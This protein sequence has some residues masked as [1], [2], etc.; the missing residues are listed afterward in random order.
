MALSRLV[1]ACSLILLY[2]SQPL[3]AEPAGL[4]LTALDRYVA[5]PDSNY[6]YELSQTITGDDYVTFIVNMTSQKYLTKK[7]VNLPVWEHV[8][9]ITVPKKV[10]SKVGYLFVTGGEKGDPLRDAAPTWNIDMAR[11][12]GTVVTTLYMVPNQPLVFTNDANTSRIEDSIVA[13]TWDKYLRSGDEKWPLRLP[14]TKAVVRAMDTV[15]NLTA[16]E[17]GGG[18]EVQKF[19]VAGASKRGWATWTTAAVDKR[20]IAIVPIVIDVLNLEPSFKHH[21]EV[22]GK[23]AAAVD[24]YSE[25]GIMQ[26]IDTPEYRAL[27]KLVEPY[28]YRDR[29]MLP[30]YIVSATGDQFFLPDS[31]QF[32]WSGLIGEKH[33]RYV[34]NADHSLADTDALN[35]V[36]AWYHAIVNNVPVPRYS[37]DVAKDGTIS[38][39][40][41]DNPLSVTLWVAHNPNARNF[42][43]NVIGNAYKPTPLKEVEPGRYTVKPEVPHKGH[44][45]YFVEMTYASGLEVPFKFS[46]GVKILPDTLKYSWQKR[47]V[48]S[49]APSPPKV[50]V[51]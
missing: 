44:I 14:M 31:W 12:T 30:K 49:S 22:Y 40:T 6:R 29:L 34:A 18:I 15:S 38:V 46:T 9:T 28:E 17:T 32:Y 42:M 13:Y 39:L 48:S 4:D 24:D 1:C 11:L 21:F 41:L 51:N 20:V 27:M 33:M 47:A 10:T 19:V 8:M 36:M 5:A 26:W 7:E 50:I 25:L 43:Q 16:S 37:W 3:V 35:S 45:A 2:Q 23:F